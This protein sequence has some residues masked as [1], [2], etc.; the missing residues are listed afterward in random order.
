M[1]ETAQAAGEERVQHTDGKESASLKQ[2]VRQKGLNIPA[3][4]LAQNE[5]GCIEVTE[6][7]EI[8]PNINPVAYRLAV[9]NGSQCGYCS[10]GFVMNMTAFLANN[11]RPTKKQIEGA[12]DG[13]ICRC[14]GYRPILTAMK[15]FAV[16]WTAEDEAGRMELLLDDQVQAQ[17]VS[18]KIHIPFPPAARQRVTGTDIS[19]KTATWLMPASV[20]ELLKIYQNYP[21]EDI[22]LLHANT[23]YGVY[24]YDFLTSKVLVDIRQ[25]PDQYCLEKTDDQLH[26][27]TGTTYTDF[28]TYLE[29]LQP[30]RPE[31]TA[32][33]ALQFMAQRTAGTIV[34]NAATLGGNTMLVFKHIHQGTGEPFPSDLF[35]VLAAL[36]AKIKFVDLASGEEQ[37]QPISSILEQVCA[38]QSCA[39]N[40]LLLRYVI[41]LH[42][43]N[44]TILAQ[45]VALRDINAHS[46]VNATS[47]MDVADDLCVESA[48]LTFGA[49]APFPWRAKKT[50]EMLTGETLSLEKF[51]ELAA[52]LAG[53]VQVELDSWRER[54]A[55]VEFEGFTDH[56]RIQLASAFLFKAIVTGIMQKDPD[57]VPER[58]RSAAEITWG[59]WPVSFGRQFYQNQSYKAP[60]SQPYVKLMALYQTSGQVRYTHEMELPPS[61]MSASFVQSTQA[62]ANYCFKN[63]DTG[64][65]PISAEQLSAYLEAHFPVFQRLISCEDIPPNGLQDIGMG[66]DQP[67]FAQLQVMYVG[68]SI[69]LVIGSDETKTNELADFVS[70]HCIHFSPVNWQPA[71]QSP[72]LGLD[73]AISRGS[74]FPDYPATAPF[75]SHIW[76]IVRN[77]S[78]FSWS[79]EGKDPLDKAINQRCATVDG[80]ACSVVDNTQL[81]GAQVHFYMET[82][83]C[84][85]IQGEGETIHFHPSTQSPMEMHLTAASV[86]GLENNQIAVHVRQL[87][88]GYG[89][90]TEQ[91]KLALAATAVAARA[92]NKPI[93]LVMPR[94]NDTRLV[95]KRHPYYG[96]Y[97]IAIDNG[98]DNPENR[99]LI[100][101]LD[102]SMYGDGGAFY[103]CSYIVSNCIQTRIDNAY[104]VPN[105]RS[106]IDV[107]RTNTA[108]NTAFRGFGDIQ[109]KLISENAIDDAA[110]SIG[111]DADEVREKNLYKRGDVTPFGQALSYCYIREVWAYLKQQADL[112][113]RKQG[114]SDFNTKNKWRKRGIYMLPVKYGSG[115]NLLQL[116]QASALVSVYSGDG[117]VIINQ[118]GVDMGQGLVTKVEQIASYTLNVPMDMIRINLPNTEIVPNPTSTGGSTGTAYNGLAV[119]QTCER[120]RAR[121]MAFGMEILKEKGN[122]WCQ[123][124]GLDFWNYG[125]TGWAAEVVVDGHKKLVWQCLVELAYTRRVCLSEVFNAEVP[126]GEEPMPNLV[127]KTLKQARGEAI[128]GI[129]VADSL[130]PGGFD[131][132][133]GFT[134]SAACSEVELDVLTGEV[135]ILRTDLM[136]DMGW[137]INPALDIGQ[138]EGAFI[139]GVG[140]V[141]TEQLVFEPEGEEKGRLNSVNTW[142]YKPPATTNIPLEFNVHLFP[143]DLAGNVPENP[144]ELMSAKEVGEPPL[145]LASS[146]FFAIKAAVRASRIE[147]GLSGLF[148]L[149]APATVQEVR[150]A[151]E[152]N[153]S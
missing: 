115:Y 32:L 30:C 13:N 132:F 79:T 63:P 146:V 45:K 52:V 75:I 46:I 98:T 35:T 1:R 84:V 131:S 33:G 136:Y 56:Y 119:K 66:G 144:N 24:K 31:T 117:S 34:R 152:V 150:R 55:E 49:I 39:D 127:Y 95:G 100:R 143:R 69:A 5:I 82:Q 59:H 118:G 80:A 85:A 108:P 37:L 109:G 114:V 18:D 110:F 124:N 134:Y 9:N 142:R 72:V 38:R 140:Y 116:E 48:R 44:N 153:F 147:R 125:D 64:E 151:C 74:I 40:I 83:S 4:A 113:V 62:L 76:K 8:D 27:G 129:D 139:Q 22:Y 149:D 138:V 135:K 86:L 111:M 91:A 61:V 17:Y 99:G 65:H 97:Q 6:C 3:L 88:G 92:M 120:L 102:L 94:D 122:E 12:F 112:V 105:L 26:V 106:T 47:V 89:G 25:I 11:P 87:G 54:M 10:T 141:M 93:R 90:K 77:H 123:Q 36:D 20:E 71:W 15:T 14:T 50:E 67:V 57:F 78:D 103:D 29:S 81:T 107:C 23:A 2:K 73:E 58:D 101:G 16:D 43:D 145:V 96:Q 41:P 19:G 148:K 126:G 21:A 133:C 7:D 128:P 28:L 68:Q 130:I 42:H 121:L 104:M 51:D 53:E 60:V 137:S 70:N